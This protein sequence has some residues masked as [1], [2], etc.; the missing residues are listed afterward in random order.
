MA[1]IVCTCGTATEI[2]QIRRAADEFCPHC[3]NPLFWM[4]SAVPVTTPG[5]NSA[6]TLRRLPGAGGRQRVG[7]RVC[8]ACGE[9]NALTETFCT[10]CQAELDPKPVEPIAEIIA[11][12][13]PVVIA[14]PD[15]GT[16]WWWWAILVAAL[17]A[18]VI[19]AIIWG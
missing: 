9:L 12:P 7:S 8:P 4:P 17:T 6:T 13:E 19:A 2:P 11:T 10:R 5:G 1:E 18:A 15:P 16:P 14:E 3:D